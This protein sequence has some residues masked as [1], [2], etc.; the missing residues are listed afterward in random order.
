MTTGASHNFWIV[1]LLNKK[2]T[3]FIYVRSERRV[4]KR[5]ISSTLL[6]TLNNNISLLNWLTTTQL[7]LAFI[8]R[9]FTR[10]KSSKLLISFIVFL[11]Y[12]FANPAAESAV[13]H[14]AGWEYDNIFRRHGSPIPMS[15]LSLFSS[16]THYPE[17]VKVLLNLQF[18]ALGE[19]NNVWNDVANGCSWILNANIMSSLQ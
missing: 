17:E 13:V 12:H 15:S 19:V 14:Q 8:Q 7:Y 16:F 10:G 1:R 6:A 5:K 4:N 2:R 3:C 11:Y 9:L 18:P